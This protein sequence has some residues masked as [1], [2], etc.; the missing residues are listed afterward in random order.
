[1]TAND[2]I[3]IYTHSAHD[4]VKRNPC[5]CQV[6]QPIIWH[7]TTLGGQK[8]RWSLSEVQSQ[9]QNGEERGFK[10][11]NTAS[12]LVPLRLGFEH[13]TNCSSATPRISSVYRA[14]LGMEKD[15]LLIWG[16]SAEWAGQWE[17]YGKDT[18]TQITTGYNTCREASLIGQH[19]KDLKAV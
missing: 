4:N 13:V 16:V 12:L 7:M 14:W 8:W 19:F 17:T 18:A 11:L 5:C 9:C 3:I 15:D 1:M 10:W 2:N 6:F